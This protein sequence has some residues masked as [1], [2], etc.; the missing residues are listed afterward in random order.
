M[1]PTVRA[2]AQENCPYRGVLYGGLMLT[3]DGPKVLE[4]NCRLGDPE[5]QVILPR[6]TTDLV[7]IL[8]SVADGTLSKTSME[9]DAETCVGVVMASGGYPS[10]YATGIPISGLAQAEARGL[11][12]HAGTRQEREEG[13]PIVT[14]GGRVLT[15]VGKGPSMEE[16]RAQAYEGVAQIRF[17]G[18]FYRRD[19]AAGIGNR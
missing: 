6:L 13:S 5:T 19:I 18:G 3:E 11:V 16:A 8:L 9:W 7:K 15:M 14:D 1:G 10:S 17:D 2:L 4:F 12:F